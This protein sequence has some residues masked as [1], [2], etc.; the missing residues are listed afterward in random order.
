MKPT[1]VING[2]FLFYSIRAL[3]HNPT[4]FIVKNRQ[5]EYIITR[6]KICI[7]YA[8]EFTLWN[9]NPSTVYTLKII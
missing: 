3:L 4:C 8:R 2:F 7:N 5:M 9:I 6:W 1:V